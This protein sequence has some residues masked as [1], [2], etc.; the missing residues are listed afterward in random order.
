MD[1]A[2][3]QLPTSSHEGSGE[4]RFLVRLSAR[5]PALW[6]WLVAPGVDHRCS[7]NFFHLRRGE[8]GCVSITAPGTLAPEQLR[9]SLRLQLD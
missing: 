2:A 1:Q 9:D 4:D 5:K 7:D 8:P 6:A 3:E